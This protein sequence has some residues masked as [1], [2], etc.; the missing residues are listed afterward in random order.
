[1]KKASIALFATLLCG[2]MLFLAGCGDSYTTE[3]NAVVEE[4][5]DFGTNCDTCFDL[6]AAVWDNVGASEVS[7]ALS[8]YEGIDYKAI[9]D[10]PEITSGRAVFFY[11]G[12]DGFTTSVAAE[13][14]REMFGYSADYSIDKYREYMPGL[15]ALISDQNTKTADELG[16]D[17][18][19]ATALIIAYQQ[20]IKAAEEE[21]ESIEAGLK[22]LNSAGKSHADEVKD[23]REW[24]G[25]V[26]SY[27]KVIKEPVG[28]TLADFRKEVQQHKSAIEKYSKSL[29]IH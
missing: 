22:K 24:Y 9:K 1:M 21:S 23:L 15:L 8:L 10:D 20:A 13:F 28:Y 17:A 11:L 6:V 16:K 19:N 2:C 26:S 25:E 7:K 5:K 4:L 29:D 14:M 12:E 18:A 3:Y 27:L